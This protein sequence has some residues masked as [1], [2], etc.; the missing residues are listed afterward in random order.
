MASR[1][2]RVVANDVASYPAIRKASWISA[3]V[4]GSGSMT[5]IFSGAMSIVVLRPQGS[6]RDAYPRR[7]S[8]NLQMFGDGLS[9]PA[10]RGTKHEIHAKLIGHGVHPPAVRI[11]AC[12]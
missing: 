12:S 7:N 3:L 11:D 6:T 9:K 1:A 2:S 8:P 5:I 10:I 4:P